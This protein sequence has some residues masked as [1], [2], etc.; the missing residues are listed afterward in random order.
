MF[1]TQQIIENLVDVSQLA[2]ESHFY[3][4]DHYPKQN[5]NNPIGYKVVTNVLDQH[6]SHNDFAKD[7]YEKYQV[8]SREEYEQLVES[9]IYG[10][11]Y[12]LYELKPALSYAIEQYGR[13]LGIRNDKIKER[14]VDHSHNMP[15]EIIFMRKIPA[16]DDIDHQAKIYI[17]NEINYHLLN[18]NVNRDDLENPKALINFLRFCHDEEA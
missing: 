5:P 13:S 15:G 6:V 8:K 3:S 7:V 11:D 10:H 9:V 18:G 17:E 2:I 14:F 4:L 12:R 1:T 16:Y